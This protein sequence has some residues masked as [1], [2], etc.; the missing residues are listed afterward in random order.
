MVNFILIITAIPVLVLLYFQWKING[1]Q[2]QFIKS[3]S[4]SLRQLQE[5]NQK[6]ISTDLFGLSPNCAYL[7]TPALQPR[8]VKHRQQLLTEHVQRNR[9]RKVYQAY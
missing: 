1:Q 5:T 3:E 2:E 8:I 9:S 4:E 7:K 6:Y